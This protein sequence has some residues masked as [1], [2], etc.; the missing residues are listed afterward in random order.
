MDKL[1]YCLR[2]F[3]FAFSIEAKPA[4]S[5]APPSV[6]GM[7]DGITEPDGGGGGRGRGQG[8]E[9]VRVREQAGA[10]RRGARGTTETVQTLSVGHTEL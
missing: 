5:K 9:S 4:L 7:N 1:L 2:H 3:Y 6:P 10:G 8:N